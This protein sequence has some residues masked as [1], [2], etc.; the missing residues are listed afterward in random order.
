M[1]NNGKYETKEKTRQTTS[2]RHFPSVNIC[3][4]QVKWNF[5]CKDTVFL[6]IRAPS[7]I[8]APPSRKTFKS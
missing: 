2:V 5:L 7:L 6:L 3:R 4:Q 8:V 1:R